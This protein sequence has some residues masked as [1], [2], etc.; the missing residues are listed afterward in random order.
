MRLVGVR[1]QIVQQKR[2]EKTTHIIFKETGIRFLLDGK[3]RT[4]LGSMEHTG[5]FGAYLRRI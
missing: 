3:N 2:K 4:P 5:S 1:R